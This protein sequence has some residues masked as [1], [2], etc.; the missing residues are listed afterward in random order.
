LELG[1]RSIRS[2]GQGSGSIEVTLPSPLRDLTGLPCHVALRDG[3]RPEIVLA[4]DLRPAREAMMRLWAL[5][6]QALAAPLGVLPLAEIGIALKPDAGLERLAWSDAL[7]LA[8][9][10]PHAP[11]ALCRALRSMAR[12]AASAL[13]LPEASSGS[14]AAALAF[15][16]TG[17]V[18]IPGDQEACDIAAAILANP[19]AGFGDDAFAASLWAAATPSMRRLLTLH[20]DFCANPERLA[21]LRRAWRQGVA[22]ELTGD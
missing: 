10:P 21:G 13:G 8:G 20:Q 18:P 16:I 22:L 1:I 7:A 3:L 14:F 19:T 2:A 4:P 6:G 15:S 12:H 11:G 5:L 17:L 9:A